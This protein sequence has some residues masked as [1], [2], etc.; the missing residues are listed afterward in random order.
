VLL[1]AQTQNLQRS[2]APLVHTARQVIQLRDLPTVRL[3]DAALGPQQNLLLAPELGHR[4]ADPD[5][6]VRCAE[7]P[8]EQR[9]DRLPVSIEHREPLAGP[10]HREDPLAVPA[11]S[12]A[13]R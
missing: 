5:E 4:L 2:R 6:L 13:R 11:L 8:T 10:A 1:A 7:I 12:I 9:D 3:G